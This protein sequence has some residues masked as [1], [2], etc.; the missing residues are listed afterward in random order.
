MS[1]KPIS[2][3]VPTYNE[4]ENI[5]PLCERLFAALKK[6]NLEGD[7]LYMD[8]ESSGSTKK[9]EFNF[10]IL[11]SN[12]IT[13]VIAVFIFAYNFSNVHFRF[14]FKQV[15]RRQKLWES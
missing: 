9:Y 12:S 15:M 13:C 8:D 6:A 11:D 3:V 1:K 2:V 10:Q 4:T 7:L 14:E 5:R